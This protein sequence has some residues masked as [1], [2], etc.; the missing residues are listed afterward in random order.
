VVRGYRSSKVLVQGLGVIEKYSGTMGTRVL[1]R[2]LGTCV[3]K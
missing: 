1:Q 2:C 3:V